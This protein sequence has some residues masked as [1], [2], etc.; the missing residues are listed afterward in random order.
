MPMF[1][2][3]PNSFIQQLSRARRLLLHDFGCRGAIAKDE[4]QCAR[5]LRAMAIWLAEF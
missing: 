4:L 3:L 2:V 5:A 1:H